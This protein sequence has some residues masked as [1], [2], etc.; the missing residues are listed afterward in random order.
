MIIYKG[1]IR[2]HLEYCIQ[3]SSS[4]LVKDKLLLENVQRRATS[5]FMDYITKAMR[6]DC[7][8]LV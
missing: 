4:S 6:T 2:P 1:Y 3:A 5:W 8:S 7:E